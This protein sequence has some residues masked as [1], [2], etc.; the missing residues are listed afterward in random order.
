MRVADA[1]AALLLAVSTAAF[2]GENIDV[3]WSVAL[4][5][6]VVTGLSA[7]TTL[8]LGCGIYRAISLRAGTRRSDHDRF[9]PPQSGLQ[10]HHDPNPAVQNIPSWRARVIGL[11]TL[12]RWVT[13]VDHTSDGAWIVRAG[14]DRLILPQG[15]EQ[16]WPVATCLRCQKVVPSVDISRRQRRALCTDCTALSREHR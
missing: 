1:I 11:R 16:F 13:V 12:R 4:L 10:R 15:E 2:V 7:T 8:C 14:S 6:A 9:R 5:T 3:A